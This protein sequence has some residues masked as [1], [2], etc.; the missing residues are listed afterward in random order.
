MKNKKL[1]IE[2]IK[3]MNFEDFYDLT[4][5]IDFSKISKEILNYIV[6]TKNIE[7][8][9]ILAKNPSTPAEILEKLLEQKNESIQFLVAE[10]PNISDK[11]AKELS[12]HQRDYIRSTLAKNKSL[13]NELFTILSKDS[14]DYCFFVKLELIRNPNIPLDVLIPLLINLSN[15]EEE[16]VREEVAMNPLTPIDTLEQLFKDEE[17]KVQINVLKNINT[18]INILIEAF[19]TKDQLMRNTSKI[20]PKMS[21]FKILDNELIIKENKVR[22]NK[23][24]LE[25]LMISLN[26]SEHS[27][28]G[29]SLIEVYNETQ[30]KLNN[31]ILKL[32]ENI[33]NL[34]EAIYLKQEETSITRD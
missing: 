23:N 30:G 18:P 15:S 11:A 22:E 20:H 19:E 4:Y 31:E 21:D 3:K 27:K 12:N 9:I 17:R 28:V 26:I 2:L 32:K 10:H 5:N 8:L 14:K 6:E 29:I 34:K 25:S 7:T 1:T 16:F 13:S 33:A 24:H